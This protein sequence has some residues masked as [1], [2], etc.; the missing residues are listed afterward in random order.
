M[1]SFYNLWNKI[2]KYQNYTYCWLLMHDFLWKKKHLFIYN[3]ITHNNTVYI[4]IYSASNTNPI[5]Y[6]QSDIHQEHIKYVFECFSSL[7]VFATSLSFFFTVGLVEIRYILK[8]FH[9]ISFLIYIP[10]MS[11]FSET[12]HELRERSCIM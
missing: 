5:Q 4:I 10:I 8:Y 9:T 6:L 3:T 1:Y 11:W 12:I 7:F 2:I